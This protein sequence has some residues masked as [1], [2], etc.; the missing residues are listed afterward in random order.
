MHF[1]RFFSEGKNVLKKFST[2]VRPDGEFVTTSPDTFISSSGDK[3]LGNLRG[4][5]KQR[6]GESVVS[7]RHESQPLD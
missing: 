3:S 1:S 5:S 2:Q 4:W 6:K 7:E